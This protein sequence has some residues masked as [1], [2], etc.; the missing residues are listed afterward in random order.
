MPTIRIDDDV[1]N[2]LKP[3]AEPFTDTPNSVIRKLLEG[4]GALPTIQTV[5]ESAVGVL[6]KSAR[7]DRETRMSRSTGLISQPTYEKYL[8]DVLAT[9]FN[10]KGDRQEV[11]KAVIALLQTRE[12]SI[13]ADPE[14]VKTGETKAANTIAWGRNALRERGLIKLSSPLGTWELAEKGVTEGLGIL[15]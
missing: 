7:A 14:R 8:L 4:R 9:R 1:F 10:G 3:L 15:L 12:P 2:G 11:T 6:A 5:Q 13:T